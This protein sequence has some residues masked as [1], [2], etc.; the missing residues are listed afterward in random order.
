MHEGKFRQL[1]ELVV[2]LVIS[3]Y[4][5]ANNKTRQLS[6]LGKMVSTEKEK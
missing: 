3:I 4:D 6:T 1:T 5:E 2:E